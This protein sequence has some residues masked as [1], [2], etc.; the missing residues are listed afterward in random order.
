MMP[1]GP[2]PFVDNPW[3]LESV[4]A[5]PDPV[6]ARRVTRASGEASATA[7]LALL[8]HCSPGFDGEKDAARIAVDPAVADGRRR[9]S[10]T[11]L[12]DNES[13]IV[14]RPGR[15]AAAVAMSG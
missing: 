3:T 9:G 4:R 15:L 6:S 5:G 8:G 10:A 13:G 1:A 2:S 12:S 11:S 7:R 14:V